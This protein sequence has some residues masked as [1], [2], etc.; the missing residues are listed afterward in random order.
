MGKAGKTLS[1]CDKKIRSIDIYGSPVMIKYRGDEFYKTKIGSLATVITMAVMLSFGFQKFIR[2]INRE[3]PEIV[4]FTNRINL[5]EEFPDTNLANAN[6]TIMAS[7][8][9]GTK[10]VHVDDSYGR[11]Y[12]GYQD[13][14]EEDKGSAFHRE[15]VE[16]C[17]NKKHFVAS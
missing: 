5:I 6:I 2:W 15:P 8:T 14:R 11:W 17:D 10:S 1:K 13:T 16:R 12:A 7:F 4:S 3:R 9:Q